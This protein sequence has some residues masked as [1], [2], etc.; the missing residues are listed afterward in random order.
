MPVKMKK[1]NNTFIFLFDFAKFLAETS[2]KKHK[3]CN[4]E[5]SILLTQSTEAQTCHKDLK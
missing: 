3:L 1:Q 2:E 5:A 4:E